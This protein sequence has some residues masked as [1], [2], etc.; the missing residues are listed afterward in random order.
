[1]KTDITLDEED[2]KNIVNVLTNKTI[3]KSSSNIPGVLK[4]P[5]SKMEEE[6]WRFENYAGKE[7]TPQQPYNQ[8][9]STLSVTPQQIPPVV[10]SQ[11]LSSFS[12]T[13]QDS[14]ASSQ[15]PKE[16][17]ISTPNSLLLTSHFKAQDGT[18]RIY[19][20]PLFPYLLTPWKP[21]YHCFPARPVPSQFLPFAVTFFERLLA[22]PLWLP[23]IHRNSTTNNQPSTSC[24]PSHSPPPPPLTSNMPRFNPSLPLS[25]QSLISATIFSPTPPV[26]DR[27]AWPSSRLNNLPLGLKLFIHKPLANVKPLP[28]TFVIALLKKYCYPHLLPYL[29]YLIGYFIICILCVYV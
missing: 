17:I 1:M 19:S 13:S 18:G 15:Q 3:K 12:S 23:S 14:K 24:V 6:G 7:I 27:S 29:E 10:L 20:N 2:L 9:Q 28:A 21:L 25:P 11:E 26:G 4:V 22:S 5:S 8:P 16:K